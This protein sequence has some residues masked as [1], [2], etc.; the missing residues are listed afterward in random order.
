MAFDETLV[1]R[2]REYLLKFSALRIEEKKMFRGVTFLVDEK[3]C[4][5]VR[6]DKLMCRFDPALHQQVEGSFGFE[7]LIMKGKELGGYCYVAPAGIREQRDLEY[8]LN[9][10][11]EYNSRALSSKKSRKRKAK[12]IILVLPGSGKA[13]KIAGNLL[14][15]AI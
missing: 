15:R 12:D 11:L 6:G 7:P 9:L 4:R 5:A 14:N 13:G 2:I 10:C 3:L 1:K 8:W